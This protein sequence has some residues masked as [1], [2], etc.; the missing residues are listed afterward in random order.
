MQCASLPE[1]SPTTLEH[2]AVNRVAVVPIGDVTRL[3]AEM[4][5]F[6]LQMHY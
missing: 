6:C 4:Q 1:L 5:V 2:G 3:A